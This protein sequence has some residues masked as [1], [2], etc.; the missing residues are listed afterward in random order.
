MTGSAVVFILILAILF[1][2]VIYRNKIVEREKEHTLIIKNKELQLLRSIIDTQENE[3]E[4]N[5]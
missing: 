4:K 2:V 1:F 5:F 3:R